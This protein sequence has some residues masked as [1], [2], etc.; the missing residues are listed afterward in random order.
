MD[1]NV[2]ILIVDD[3]INIRKSLKTILS[4]EGYTVDLAA[5][6]NEAIKKT[7][8]EVYNIALIDIRL[9]DMEGTELLNRMKTTVPRMRKIIITGYPSVENAIEA[10]NRKADSYLV[11]PVNIEKLLKTIRANLE[12]QEAEK[13]YNEEKVAEFIETRV[14]EIAATNH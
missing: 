4:D 3:D 10:V 12:T 9:P 2:R 11:K 5:N 1:K 6:G 13:K 14:R 8:T 7:E